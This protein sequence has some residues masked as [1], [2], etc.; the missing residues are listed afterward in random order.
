MT[1]W[2]FGCF[3]SI[4]QTCRFLVWTLPIFM[5]NG[6]RLLLFVVVLA[7]GFVRFFWYYAVA[8]NR[9]SM[10]Y[11]ND[12]CRQTLDIYLPTTTTTT[13]ASSS[14]QNDDD[15]YKRLLWNDIHQQ[16]GNDD[17]IN[18]LTEEGHLDDNTAAAISDK[19]KKK[20]ENKAAETA[21]PVVVFFTGG[22]WM[23]GYKMWGAL[24]ARAL[25]A[26]GLMVVIPDYGNYPWNGTVPT[27]VDVDVEQSLQWIVDHIEQYG[28]NRRQ[29]LLV[30]QSAGGHLL[31][32]A[33]L[34]KAIQMATNNTNTNTPACLDRR[35]DNHVNDKNDDNSCDINNNSNNESTRRRCCD[36]QPTDF[37]GFLSL[38]APYDLSS[39][40]GSGGMKTHF[41]DMV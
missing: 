24:L 17:A 38:S 15:S 22:A 10:R 29:I 3:L 34:R 30:G 28:G 12:S 6:M 40:D 35:I 14:R 16:P 13:T 26:A 27:M 37:I 31:C 20:K 7:P 32:T 8:S 5:W 36:W 4:R 11:G 23:I 2:T 33:L 18:S 41:N 21:V 9:T 19:T 1:F 25:T 39:R